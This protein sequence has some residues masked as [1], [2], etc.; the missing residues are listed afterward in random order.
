MGVLKQK[1]EF[2]D[3]PAMNTKSQEP[4]NIQV[5]ISKKSGGK[6]PSRND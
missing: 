2:Y 1:A 4:E 5:M 3:S 6:Q